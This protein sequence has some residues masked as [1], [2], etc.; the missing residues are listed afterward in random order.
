MREV[1]GASL[2]YLHGDHPSTSLGA[3]RPT[4]RRTGLRVRRRAGFTFILRPLRQ[5]QGKR[6]GAIPPGS[7]WVI[8]RGQS[9]TRG[10][11]T[12][13]GPTHAWIGLLLALSRGRAHSAPPLR[14][15]DQRIH[16]H[17][18]QPDFE[19]QVRA[20]GLTGAAH[21]RNRLPLLHRLTGADK[22]LAVVRVVGLEAVARV[23]SG[24]HSIRPS[25]PA[26][27]RRVRKVGGG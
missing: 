11:N 18:V 23:W 24:W 2:V 6:A 26:I 5:A 1:A 12:K 15:I 7:V 3:C 10:F 8:R 20:R 9:V 19:M 14:Q 4:L 17:A 21:G 27:S 25:L 13:E 22:K 16:Q